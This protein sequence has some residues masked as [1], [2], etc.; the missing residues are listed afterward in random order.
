MYETLAKCLLDIVCVCL[1]IWQWVGEWEDDCR[2]QKG[3]WE[4]LPLVL[5]HN[6]YCDTSAMIRGLF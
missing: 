2:V 6:L 1:L 5:G 4:G 3:G